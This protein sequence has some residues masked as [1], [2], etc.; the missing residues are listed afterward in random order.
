M[1]RNRAAGNTQQ[2]IESAAVRAIDSHASVVR[3]ASKV[4]DELDEVTSPHGVP[5]V[6]LD[7]EDSMVISLVAARDAHQKAD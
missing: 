2:R 4:T 5:V 3:A 6:D 7:D 1:A